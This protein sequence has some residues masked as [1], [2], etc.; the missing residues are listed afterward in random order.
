M[1]ER[2]VR[3]IAWCLLFLAASLGPLSGC[4]TVQI[5]P[6]ERLSQ[7]R[8]TTEA[9]P[10]A[11]IYVANWGLYLFKYLPVVT[12]DLARPGAV[13]WPAFF[14]NQVQISRLVEKVGQESQQLGGTV[15]TDLRTRDRSYWMP[16]S[17]IFWLNE[18]E[19]SANASRSPGPAD[20][21]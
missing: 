13:R 5:V 9:A 6:V 18:F 4:A 20:K 11:H 1:G 12:G 8:L 14:T 16:Y 17:L 3:M 10:V 2:M 21:R 19:V 15:I 7:Q